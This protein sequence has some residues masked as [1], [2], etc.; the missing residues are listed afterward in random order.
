MTISRIYCNRETRQAFRLIWGGW[1]NALEKAT[2]KRL[3]MKVI[4]KE[5]KLGTMLM[6]GSAPQIQGLGDV[7]IKENN[8]SVSGIHT[9]D[10]MRIVIPLVRTCDWHFKHNLDPLS[11]VLTKEEM[12]RIRLFRFLITQEE[13]DEFIE[14]ASTHEEKKLRDWIANKVAHPW[15]IPSLCRHFSQIPQLDWDLSPADN[16]LN[17]TSHPATNKA[18]GIGLT[19]VEVIETTKPYDLQVYTD[20]KK[21]DETCVQR[22]LH[23]T[24]MHRLASNGRRMNSRALRSNEDHEM[25]VKLTAITQ[26]L[27]EVNEQKRA[28]AAR[29]K[30]LR[31]VKKQTSGGKNR[32][33]KVAAGR[34]PTLPECGDIVRYSEKENQ[35]PFVDTSGLS[36]PTP[37]QLDPALEPPPPS[38]YS[39]SFAPKPTLYS[40]PSF[41]PSTC[42]PAFYEGIAPVASSSTHHLHTTD[43][44]W[45]VN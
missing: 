24:I 43:F 15:Y 26:Q 34:R 25:R 14:W 35:D 40:Y 31:E 11:E 19:L 16:N 13:M 42:P 6:D 32:K 30:E 3:K 44:T 23:N 29:S 4:H 17:E 1:L 9:M 21:L 41:P 18:T 20:R 12:D 28:L 38:A 10:A 7:L 8:P 39:S 2:G 37:L 33:L 5:G 22:N 36:G 27:A 45:N